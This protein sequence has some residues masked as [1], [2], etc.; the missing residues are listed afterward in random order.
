MLRPQTPA[1]PMPPSRLAAAANSAG[2][3][4]MLPYHG[5][6]PRGR[7]L[8]HTCV[9]AGGCKTLRSDVRCLRPIIFYPLQ[10]TVLCAAASV[11]VDCPIILS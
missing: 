10:Y 6:P 9:S 3:V 8:L 7:L 1:L 4:S 2:V 5:Q 11:S